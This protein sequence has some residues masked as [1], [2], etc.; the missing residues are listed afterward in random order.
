MLIDDEAG[1]DVAIFYCL[2]VVSTTGSEFLKQGLA[3][4]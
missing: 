1:C 3:L 2:L 4:L